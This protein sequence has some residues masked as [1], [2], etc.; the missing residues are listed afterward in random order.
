[1]YTHLDADKTLATIERLCRRIHER[2][3]QAGLSEVC[4]ELQTIANN[5]KA[6]ATKL[7]QPLYGLRFFVIVL[8]VATL[9]VLAYTVL[10]IRFSVEKLSAADFA[11][12]MDAGFNELVLLG[13]ALFFLV[14]IEARI[15]RTRV[16]KALHELRSIAHVIDMHQLTKDPSLFFTNMNATKS[17]PE[18]KMT[19]FE[20]TRYLDYCSEMLALTSKIAALYAQSFNDAVVVAAVNDFETLTASMSRKVWQKMMMVKDEPDTP[21]A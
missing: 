1:M 6:R 5:A 17:S 14:T 18:R 10:H 8:I 19:P 7:A 20:L 3:P 9:C 11:Q 2:F 16:T 4:Q 15:K 13:A 21:S 12:I